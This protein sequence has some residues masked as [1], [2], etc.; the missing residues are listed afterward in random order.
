MDNPP[1]FIMLDCI[2]ID[3]FLLLILTLSLIMVEIDKWD[4][5]KL[6]VIVLAVLSLSY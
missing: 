6:H 3:P 5:P 2:G 4:V 1:L